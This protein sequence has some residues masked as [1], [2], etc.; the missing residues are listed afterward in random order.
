MVFIL[1]L[2]GVLPPEVAMDPG[3]GLPLA[4]EPGRVFFEIQILT[5]GSVMASMVAYLAAQLCD[6]HLFHF[7]KRLTNGR[8][9]WLRNNGST[10]ISQ[11]VDTS[12]VILIA[13]FYANALPVQESQALWPQLF[14]FI[15]SG[16]VFKVTCAFLD[17]IPFYVGSRWMK[18]YLQ[19]DPTTVQ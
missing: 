2:G 19:I 3:T 9:L 17:T 7:W 10:I 11:L 14:M 8:H 18:D 6:V 15:G 5:L 16:Y 13:H 12:A 4:G 1:W